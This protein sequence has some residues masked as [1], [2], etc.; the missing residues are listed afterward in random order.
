[1]RVYSEGKDE[2]SLQDRNDD[3]SSTM[4]PELAEG[5][6]INIE[7]VIPQQHFTEPPPRFTEATLVK[8]LESYGIG[9]PSTYAPTMSTIQD[10]GYVKLEQKKFFPEDVGMVVNRFLVEH[11][12]KYVDYHFTAHLEDDLDAIS[13]GEKEWVPLLKDFWSPFKALIE[14]KDKTTTRA[15]VTTEDTEEKCPE[16]SKH[17]T[18][19]T[20]SLWSFYGLFQLS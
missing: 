17:F 15:Q 20:G 7:Q 3:D 14:D 6:K 13:R 9:R 19:K 2:V 16:C 1:M 12:E 5:D 8:V 18:D 10:R 4:L 11:F